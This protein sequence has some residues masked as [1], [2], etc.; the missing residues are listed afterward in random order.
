MKFKG[1]Q[2]ERANQRLVMGTHRFAIGA[3][4]TKGRLHLANVRALAEPYPAQARQRQAPDLR[5]CDDW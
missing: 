4:T 3:F 2:N 5:D 1:T